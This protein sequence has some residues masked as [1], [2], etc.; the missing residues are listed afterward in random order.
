[1]YLNWAHEARALEA[2]ICYITFRNETSDLSFQI[3]TNTYPHYEGTITCR[4]FKKKKNKPKNPFLRSFTP[5]TKILSCKENILNHANERNANTLD[6]T[7]EREAEVRSENNSQQ[8]RSHEKRCDTRNSYSVQPWK[9]S[10][11]QKSVQM[12]HFCRP[13]RLQM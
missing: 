13:L 8:F 12:L 6:T 3:S 11:Q 2:I 7:K 4:Y 9:G 1:M 10:G 5:R